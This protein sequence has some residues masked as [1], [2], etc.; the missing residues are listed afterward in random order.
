[1]L[2]RI[3]Q[4]VLDRSHRVDILYV[5]LFLLQQKIRSQIEND[6]SGGIMC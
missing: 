5:C 1:M 4:L 2:S 3:I 6:N